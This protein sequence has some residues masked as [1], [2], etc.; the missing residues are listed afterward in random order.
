VEKVEGATR[1]TLTKS[2]WQLTL[3]PLSG[4]KAGS[5]KEDTVV[6]KDNK[7]FSTALQKWAYPPSNYTISVNNSGVGVWETMQTSET[8]GVAFW[9]GEL[10]GE[11]MRGILSLNPKEGEALNYSF[12]AVPVAVPEEPAEAAE[13]VVELPTEAVP[14]GNAPRAA[15]PEAPLV[16]PVQA[17]NT[18]TADPV[19][20]AAEPAESL[21]VRKAV[22]PS[23]PV[24]VQEEEA[25]KSKKKGWLF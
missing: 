8:H 5:L 11:A 12:N 9:R 15:T 19:P 6:F 16:P 4:T 14:V 21:P 3:T 24:A 20:A 7:I 18:P 22:S 23:V 25:S 17:E 2:A 13:P 10:R 1:K